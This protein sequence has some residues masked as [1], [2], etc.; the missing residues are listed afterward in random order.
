MNALGQTNARNPC[1]L[2]LSVHTL[3]TVW[4]GWRA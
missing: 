1:K 4:K 3:S 2:A